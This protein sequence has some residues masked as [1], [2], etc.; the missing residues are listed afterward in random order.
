MSGSSRV[1]RNVDHV[2]IVQMYCMLLCP[3]AIIQGGKQAV[4]LSKT[5]D[6][7]V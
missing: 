3:G 4:V 7:P 6:F 5:P 1:E 2:K